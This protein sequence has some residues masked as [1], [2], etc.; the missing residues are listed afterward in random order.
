MRLYIPTNVWKPLCQLSTILL[1]RGGPARTVSYWSQSNLSNIGSF[2]ILSKLEANVTQCKRV[3]SSLGSDLVMSSQRT[4]LLMELVIRSI[5]HIFLCPLGINP[6][7]LSLRRVQATHD[8]FDLLKIGQ[9]KHAGEVK[10][11]I[12]EFKNIFSENE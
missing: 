3:N 12:A 5:R 1:E 9:L 8:L 4:I 10:S 7:I 6:E 11:L 2:Q